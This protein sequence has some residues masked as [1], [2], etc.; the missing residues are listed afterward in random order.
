VQGPKSPRGPDLGVFASEV[1]AEE[2]MST[3]VVWSR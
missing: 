2:E 3:E 1:R